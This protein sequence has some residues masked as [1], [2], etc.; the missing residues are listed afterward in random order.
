MSEALNRIKRKNTNLIKTETTNCRNTASYIDMR[1]KSVQ[2]YVLRSLLAIL[3]HNWCCVVLAIEWTGQRQYTVDCTKVKNEM[4]EKKVVE[5]EMQCMCLR[6]AT[7]MSVHISTIGAN[8]KKIKMT[9]PMNIAAI[10]SAAA[11][12]AGSITSRRHNNCTNNNIII[13]RE[14]KKY[15]HITRVHASRN[16][17]K[18]TNRE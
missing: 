2:Q 17:R 14:W 7:N 11:A 9:K 12:A 4:K 15:A 3:L 8:K 5:Q 10:G 6:M 1:K 13:N 18:A 16:F